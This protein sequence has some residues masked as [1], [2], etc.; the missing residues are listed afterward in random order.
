MQKL[1]YSVSFAFLEFYASF[2]WFSQYYSDEKTYIKNHFDF[3]FIQT[4]FRLLLCL[5]WLEHHETFY[6]SYNNKLGTV[7]MLIKL[8]N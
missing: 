7:I 6:N 2:F 4:Y 1:R 8:K 5:V 3:W